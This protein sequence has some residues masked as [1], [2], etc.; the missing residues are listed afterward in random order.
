MSSSDIPRSVTTRSKKEEFDMESAIKE[1]LASHRKLE[2]T[3]EK[4]F[5]NTEISIQEIE[6]RLQIV[7]SREDEPKAETP[8]P[9]FRNPVVPSPVMTPN[10]VMTTFNLDPNALIVLDSG[11]RSVGKY[12]AWVASTQ[13]MSA[14]F[15]LANFNQL[16]SSY[17]QF[18]VRRFLDSTLQEWFDEKFKNLGPIR[19]C[20][21]LDLLA[22]QQLWQPHKSL[23]QF[24]KSRVQRPSEPVSNFHAD[25]LSLCR[26]VFAKLLAE[27]R[28][29]FYQKYF[30]IFSENVLPQLVDAVV[31]AEAF[32]DT[33]SKRSSTSKEPFHPDIWFK[34]VLQREQIT[35]QAVL[36]QR[37]LDPSFPKEFAQPFT[38][39]Q[40][41]KPLVVNAVSE[42][43][44]LICWACRKPGHTKQH[45][46]DVLK[47]IDDKGTVVALL[48]DGTWCNDHEDQDSD[49]QSGDPSN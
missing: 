40:K 28:A 16:V 4:G 27:N 9:Q 14:A 13:K 26:I 25:L 46:P 21:F 23:K 22:E 36:R 43:P 42:K 17:H 39:V 29:K 10:Q 45:C 18:P 20:D 24:V 7:E 11:S 34:L 47:T 49:F 19:W 44:P 30:E 6:A 1:L 31:T 38:Q 37:D 8:H 12:L 5:R 41:K 3:V 15:N 35:A 2:A 33:N 48:R 32:I